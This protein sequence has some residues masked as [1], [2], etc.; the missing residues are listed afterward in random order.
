MPAVLTLQG[1]WAVGS[2]RGM[3]ASAQ[4]SLLLPAALLST[5]CELS[6]GGCG[7]GSLFLRQV[8]VWEE[9][10]PKGVFTRSVSKKK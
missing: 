10:C 5:H 7:F 9:L 1:D 4:G 6:C 3:D 8:G 2:V